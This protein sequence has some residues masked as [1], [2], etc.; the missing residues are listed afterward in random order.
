[1]ADW[2]EYFT[3]LDAIASWY[4]CKTPEEVHTAMGKGHHVWTGSKEI[5]WSATR[6]DPNYHAV[7]G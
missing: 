3:E 4:I 7:Y 5:D 6:R 1:M 2:I